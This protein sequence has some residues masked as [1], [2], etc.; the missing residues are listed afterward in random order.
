M[1]R[2][3]GAGVGSAIGVFDT[4]A[5]RL[6]GPVGMSPT[7][8]AVVSL[9]TV[10]LW[11]F[12]LMG[13]LVGLAAYTVQLVPALLVRQFLDELSGPEPVGLN[14]WTPLALLAAFALV[15]P[16]VHIG[17]FVSER[18]LQLIVSTLLRHN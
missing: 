14:T 12:V 16:A 2:A 3:R 9:A 5:N 1:G 6:A 10:R 18:S 17:A 13:A 15:R 8:R 4:A 11:L 7:W